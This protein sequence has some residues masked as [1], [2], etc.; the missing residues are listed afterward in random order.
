MIFLLSLVFL[1][2]FSISAFYPNESQPARNFIKN[3]HRQTPLSINNEELKKDAVTKN[4]QQPKKR[5]L[6]FLKPPEPRALLLFGV[7]YITKGEKYGRSDTIIL[8]LS[9][10]STKEIALL[11]IPRDTYINIPGHGYNKINTAF[12]L[13]GPQ[14]TKKTVGKWLGIPIEDTITIDYDG[15]TKLINLLGGLEI[16]V[17]K[18]MKNAEFTLKEGKRHLS[19]DEVLKFVRFRKSI[20]GK[21]DSDYQRM[22][23][24]HQVLTEL[25]NEIFQ[26]RPLP[27]MI[28]LVHTMNKSVDTTLDLK[29]T[30]LFT[31]YYYDFSIDNLHTLMFQGQGKKMNGI[32]YEVIPKKE[33]NEK[34]QFINNF[35]YKS[36]KADEKENKPKDATIS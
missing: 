18:T 11:S 33:L 6:S 30:L 29:E 24:Q 23:R 12:Q 8:V 13:G 17:D 34:K 25:A 9:S 15:F 31:K 20:D 4:E 22:Q 21:H 14:L 10:P 35:L 32:W 19:G 16:N 3:E 27:E 5:V 36:N 26:V 2:T 7:D 28:S 1:V